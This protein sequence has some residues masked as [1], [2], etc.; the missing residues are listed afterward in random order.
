MNKIDLENPLLFI[1]AF[2]YAAI[3]KALVSVDGKI[4]KVNHSLCDCLGYQEQDLLNRTFQEIT[5]PDDLDIDLSQMDL[6]LE[7]K[8][9]SFQMEKRYMHKNHHEIWAL[10][11]VTLVRNEQN[12]PLYFVSQIQDITDRKLAE[13]QFKMGEKRYQRLVEESPDGVIILQNG[14]CL[15]VNKAG[16]DLLGGANKDEIIGN[17][18]YDFIHVDYHNRIKKLVKNNIYTESMG[19]IEEKFV[20]IDGKEINGEIKTIPTIYQGKVA[21]HAIIRD[22]S[23]RKKTQELIIHSEKLTIAGQLAAG[24]AHEIR[25]PLTA[26]KGFLQI[27]KSD[28]EDRKMYFDV[29]FSEMN[30]VESILSELLILAKP[31]TK[32]FEQ[33]DIAIILNHIITLLKTQTNLNSIEIIETIEA[34]LPPIF[35]DENQLKQVFINILKNAIEAMPHSGK[36]HIDVKQKSNSVAIRIADQ[37]CGIPEELLNQ[38]GEPFFTTKEKGTGLGLMICKQIIESH[39]GELHIDSCDKGTMVEIILPL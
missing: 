15:F 4:M 9:N 19:P 26:I 11:S 17:S 38:I 28:F 37:G 29:I 14:K 20:R 8:I 5:H 32:K 35:C 2:D 36:I 24:I 33:K 16:V 3:G 1:H 34:N 31:Q 7:G 21:I 12:Q 27:M 13:E 18:I 23:E 39:K 6:L 10:L 30:R 22:I 25:N